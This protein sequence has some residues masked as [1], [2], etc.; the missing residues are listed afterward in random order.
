MQLESFPLKGSECFGK[1]TDKNEE[2]TAKVREEYSEL[3][4]FAELEFEKET[5]TLVNSEEL[6]CHYI[7]SGLSYYFGVE[8]VRIVP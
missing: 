5:T 3:I 1:Q 7:E 6:H 8:L 4:C 2:T